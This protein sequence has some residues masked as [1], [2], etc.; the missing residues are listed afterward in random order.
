MSTDLR[1]FGWCAWHQEFADT[2]RVI[3]IEEQ[4]SGAAGH[5]LACQ[6]CIERHGLTRIGD[7]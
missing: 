3:Y 6:P 2:V 4:G 1:G 7:Q 5:R